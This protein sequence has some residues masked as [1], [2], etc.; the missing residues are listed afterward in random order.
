M[1]DETKS[2]AL[3]PAKRTGAALLLAGKSL[4]NYA[5]VHS[6]SGKDKDSGQ[7]HDVRPRALEL[8]LATAK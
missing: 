5:I 3:P 6:V 4:A 7:V 1:V 2:I 8:R